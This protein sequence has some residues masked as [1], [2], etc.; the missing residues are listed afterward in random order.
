MTAGHS[1][2]FPALDESRSALLV[3]LRDSVTPILANNLLPHFTDHSV[4]HSDSLIELVTEL[5][6]PLSEGPKS[7][8]MDELVVLYSACYLHD[9]GLQYE[10]AYELG[11]IPDDEFSSPWSEL[12]DD[13]RRAL[14]RRHHHRVSATLV[15]LSA[16]AAPPLG[17]KLS[18]EYQPSLVAALCAAHGLPTNTD[19][20]R[21]LTADRPNVRMDLLSALLRVADILDES[22]QRALRPKAE[23][24]ALDVESLTHWWRHYYTRKVTFDTA[25]NSIRLHFEFPSARLEEYA[26]IIPELQLPVITEELDKH[27]RVFSKNSLAWHVAH[28]AGSEPYDTAEIMPED[29]LVE[30]TKQL[31][32]RLRQRADAQRAADLRAFEKAQ[33]LLRRQV[34]ELEAARE[35][36]SPADYLRRLYACAR[37]RWQLGSKR[38]ACM[39]VRFQFARDAGHLPPSERLEMAV[40]LAEWLYEDGQ[41]LGAVEILRKAEDVAQEADSPLPMR[42]RFW[43]LI[44][45]CANAACDHTRAEAATKRAMELTGSDPESAQLYAE[46]AEWQYLRGDHVELVG[47]PRT[48]EEQAVSSHTAAAMKPQTAAA[49]LG[50]QVSATVRHTMARARSVAT[51]QGTE[52]AIPLIENARSQ[53]DAACLLDTTALDLAKA[54]LLYLDGR[55]AS[56][57]ELMDHLCDV[58]RDTEFRDLESALLDD[59]TVIRFAELKPDADFYEQHDWRTLSGT[60]RWD[61]SKVL[62]GLIAAEGNKHY[63]ALPA[64][65]GQ[66]LRTHESFSWQGQRWAHERMARELLQIGYLNDAAWHAIA[67][68]D[69]ELAAQIGKAALRA[70]DAALVSALV[71]RVLSLSRPCLTDQCS[72]LVRVARCQFVV[73]A[74]VDDKEVDDG[75][76]SQAF[77]CAARAAL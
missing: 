54:E 13:A 16:S 50:S 46:R 9:V 4:S 40:E 7:L 30:M 45:R 66:L 48:K 10:R 21:C 14:L 62:E 22:R 31:R 39:M 51:S 37:D 41:E 70:R 77:W 73:H 65:W 56:A 76:T 29:V 2:R 17:L 19:E 18:E 12:S 38:A 35:T 61:A 20:Y 43:R 28:Q 6:R 64:F 52:V 68:L 5:T 53:L 8:T 23:T 15:Q 71:T 49:C 36:L 26:R 59:R 42:L 60:T 63:D 55:A 58:V 74:V 44:A 32:K 1:S 57:L 47:V 75:E 69:K 11:V 27:R 33:P 3:R 67:A 72:A 34:K 25:A 24:L